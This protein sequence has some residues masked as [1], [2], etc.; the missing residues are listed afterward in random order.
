MMFGRRM[1][2]CGFCG[3]GVLWISGFGGC[4]IKKEERPGGYRADG[5]FSTHRRIT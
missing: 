5:V 2:E 4:G 3:F 1:N